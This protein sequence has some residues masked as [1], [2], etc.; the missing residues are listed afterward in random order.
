MRRVLCTSFRE[1]GKSA[2]SAV[3]NRGATW[4][5]V[6][7]DDGLSLVIELVLS[8][9]VYALFRWAKSLRS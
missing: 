2:G 8:L 5:E 6:I 3:G 9:G 1:M 4:K 7:M